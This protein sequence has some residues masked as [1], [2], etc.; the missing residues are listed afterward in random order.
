MKRAALKRGSSPLERRT[1]LAPGDTP[2][3]QGQPLARRTALRSRP[4]QH[5]RDELEVRLMADWHKPVEAK[6]ARCVVCGSPHDLEG[7]HVV[8]QQTLRRMAQDRGI[9]AMF[10]LWDPRCRVIVCELCHTRHTRRIKP[11]PMRCLSYE[12]LTYASDLGLEWLI[13]R[14]YPLAGRIG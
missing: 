10:L 2:L 8:E 4:R 7:H 11:I 13:E 14:S 12:N 1:A 5:Q 6:D 9:P 3:G